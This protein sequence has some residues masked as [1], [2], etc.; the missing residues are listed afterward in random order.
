MIL[1]FTDRKN[2]F[3]KIR[4]LDFPNTSIWKTSKIQSGSPLSIEETIN[5]THV[6]K[7]TGQS[8][9]ATLLGSRRI[10]WCHWP[11]GSSNSCH[12]LKVML[13]AVLHIQRTQFTH[14]DS[15]KLRCAGSHW[16][17]LKL[18]SECHVW[19]F[20]WICR[21]LCHEIDLDFASFSNA[22]VGEIEITYF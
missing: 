13:L 11:L 1:F 21:V 22:C 8:T 6:F 7:I 20:L 19:V 2:I 9:S 15:W 12:V 18:E 16:V 3:S 10:G 4:Y 14:C 17:S 5:K